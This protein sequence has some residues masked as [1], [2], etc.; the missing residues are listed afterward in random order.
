MNRVNLI[1][2]LPPFL[3]NKEEYIQTFK[4]KDV[5]F[6]LLWEKINECFKNLYLHELTEYGVKRWEKIMRITPKAS[7]TLDDRRFRIINRYLTNVPYTYRKIKHILNTLCGENGYK[8][9]L[10]HINYELRVKLELYSKKQ[11]DEVKV[12]LR[13]IIPANLVLEVSIL[14]NQHS[15]LSRIKHGQLKSMTH[16]TIREEVLD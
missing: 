8:L 11:I 9:E 10:N 14:Y 12:I 16:K 4:T 1:N 15:T 6:I 2:R 3:Q 5:Q 13:R 7:D